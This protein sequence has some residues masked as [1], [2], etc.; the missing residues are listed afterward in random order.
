MI[1][2]LRT[3]SRLLVCAALTAGATGL[4]PVRATAADQC[5][6]PATT[7]VHTVPPQQT[8][9]DPQRAWTLTRGGGVTVAVLDSGVDASV[10]QLAGHVLPGADV[11][12]GSGRGDSDCVGHGTFVAGLIAAQP[13]PGI[14]FA[15]L[16]PDVR[17]LP[18]K[19]TTNGQDG[20]SASLAQAIVAAVA[21]GA[22]VINI[23]LSADAPSDE[24]QTAVQY[25][26]QRN[27][28]LVAAAANSARQGNPVTY[29][30]AYP[31]VIAVGA[32]DETGKRSD[33]S[34]TGSFLDLVAP[35]T[36][37]LSL[38]TRGP[39]H[40]LDQ[41][42]SF[43]TPFVTAVAALVRAYHP[44]LTPAQVKHRLE[45]TADHPGTALPNPQVGWG[46]VDPYA[47][48]ATILPEEGKQPTRP[49]PSPAPLTLPQAAPPAPSNSGTLLFAGG[50]AALAAVALAGA[51]VLPRGRRRGWR[52]G[53]DGGGR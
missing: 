44:E 40:A 36:N 23:S 33:F 53:G 51:V 10:P 16:A 49:A 50:G 14:G 20:S 15:G 30:A 41:G 43:A 3:P 22:Q 4:L 17:I 26:L 12:G 13:T 39:G 31:G 52:A 27:V 48:V 8:R 42:T 1:S 2:K 9:L 7:V 5:A 11:V 18:V 47:A 19:Q 35:G 38:G 37:I 29:P 46:M 24:L 45:V 28:V 34:E 6:A 32:V 25:A 21:G